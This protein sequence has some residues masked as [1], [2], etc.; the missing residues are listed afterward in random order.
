VKTSWIKIELVQK[1]HEFKMKA[2]IGLDIIMIY[3]NGKY[4]SQQEA[5]IAFNDRGFLLGDGVFE[6]MRIYDGNVFCFEDHYDRLKN[7]AELLEIPFFMPADEMIQIIKTLLAKNNLNDKNASIRMT[8]TRGAGP[9]GLLP[10]EHHFHISSSLN[11]LQKIT[12]NNSN[13]FLCKNCQ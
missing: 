1:W 5:T 3:I 13:L 8:L 10:P 4:F 2:I 7:S 12:R 11:K 9:R 6:T